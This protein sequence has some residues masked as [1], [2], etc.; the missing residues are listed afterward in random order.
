[1]LVDVSL[2]LP[3]FRTFTYEVEESEAERARPGMRAV[4]P[5]R[6][7]RE[8]GVIV[9]ATTPRDGIS[10]TPAVSLPDSEPVVSPS[11]LSLCEWMSE[12]YVVPLGIAIRCAL[13]A[14][15][16][17]HVAPEP[18]RRTRRVAVLRRELPTLMHRE[19]IFAR[20]PQQRTLFELIE[21]LGGRVPVEHLTARLNFSPSVLKG[22]VARGVV[23]IEEEI[24]ARD[25]FAWRPPPAPA[26][27]TPSAAQREAIERLTA[28]RA[29]EVFLLHGV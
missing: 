25:P 5:F 19:R 16:A 14:A 2:P 24:V 26:V 8:I 1:M 6:N 9:G 10:P 7:R 23:T 18:V 11:L 4:V 17:S 28:A 29:A 3:L 21:S 13:P 27:H 22:V 15:L 20:A 12:Y